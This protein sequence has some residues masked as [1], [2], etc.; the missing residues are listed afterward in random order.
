MSFEAGTE[1]RRVQDQA[2]DA[3]ICVH[4]VSKCY[5]LYDR[6]HDRLKQF[7]VPHVRRLMGREP[8]NYAREFWALSDVSFNV[9]KGETVGVIG[10]NGSGKSTL[11]QIICGTLTPT[12]GTVNTNGRTAALLE[13]GAGFNPEFT[14]RENIYMNGALLGLS[15]EE[16]DS[17]IDDIAAFADIGQFIEQPVKTYSSGM[18]VRL[19]F[20]IAIN[21]QPQ[22]LIVDEVLAV[23]DARFQAKCMKR[24]KVIQESGASI[25]FVSHDV[26][27]VRTLCERAIW[28][29]CGRLHMDGDVFPVTG[30]YIE[31]L[32]DDN[33]PRGV[34]DGAELP[35]SA[36]DL[37]KDDLD[38]KPITHWG[39]HIGCIK[40]AGIYG[41][42]DTRKD[43]VLWN[44]E[45]E[46]RIVFTPPSGVDRTNLSAAF[47]IKDLK[48]TDL[49]VST[50]YDSNHLPFDDLTTTFRVSCRFRNPLVTGKYFLVAAIED[51]SSTVIHYYEYLEGAHYFA[52]VAGKHLFGIF[53][54]EITQEVS[55][56]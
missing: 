6:P 47:S 49:I 26:G 28:L 32:F 29:E 10:R 46:I 12:S 15:Q 2:D 25:L 11:L 52:S 41:A 55:A 19:A 3:A 42:M 7:I 1:H 54:P 5:H 35:N 20:A 21:V 48:G 9:K 22:I 17:R 53:H 27:S 30:R 4:K 39:S 31:H 23:G 56:L 50:T 51:R 24:I 14:G 36:A 18:Y 34:P 13:L 44:E 43:V 16:I 8:K 37:H 40:L 33:T 45:I 38:R